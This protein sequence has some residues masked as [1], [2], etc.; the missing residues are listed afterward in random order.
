MKDNTSLHD[1][2]RE[3]EPEGILV[4]TRDLAQVPG[5][6]KADRMDCKWIQRLHSW[7]NRSRRWTGRW[8]K[9]SEAKA[10][11]NRTNHPR[12][13]GDCCIG[14]LG[15]SPRPGICHLWRAGACSTVS[16]T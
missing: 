5:C 3:I 8:M 9:R 2:S 13:E 12:R 11:K 7:W 14:S 15:R 10:G 1:S 6:K 4:C 16:T